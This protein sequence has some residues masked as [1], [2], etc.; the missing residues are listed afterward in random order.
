MILSIFV[1]THKKTHKKMKKN[2]AN[3]KI[4]VQM[5]LFLSFLS[6]IS[7]IKKWLKIH[8]ANFCSGL[9]TQ[10]Y[11]THY[12]RTINILSV[13]FN[14]EMRQESWQITQQL[15]FFCSCLNSNHTHV[16]VCVLYVYS[17]ASMHFHCLKGVEIRSRQR[18]G[19]K[20]LKPLRHVEVEAFRL[21]GELS[22]H[23]LIPLPHQT[24]SA[25]S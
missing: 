10:Y 13:F 14:S 8:K 2:I 7:Q 15:L 12:T 23:L 18:R 3:C 19:E 5:H 16:S 17:D 22:A 11:Q 21:W 6:H 20:L 24:T 1:H 9:L 4:S 25:I